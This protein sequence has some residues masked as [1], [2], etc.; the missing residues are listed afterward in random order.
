VT[1]KAGKGRKGS[2][3]AIIK[4]TDAKTVMEVLL[5]IDFKKLLAVRTVTLDMSNSMDWIVRQCF[6]NCT[7]IIDRFH[8][9]RLIS[10]AVQSLRV[11]YRWKVLEEENELAQIARKERVS[12]QS[13][14]YENGDSKKQLLA[15]SRYILFKT[16]NTWTESQKQRATILF[17]EYP[18]LKR[19]YELA[20]KFKYIYQTSKTKEK[21]QIR[22]QQWDRQVK[23]SNINYLITASDTVKSHEG[24]ILNYFPDRLTNA[25]AESFNAKLKGFRAL[26]RGILDISFFLFRVSKIYA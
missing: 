16:E 11:E 15:R 19:A 18:E 17:R 6:L 8:V 7:K 3:V 24:T 1:N 13:H 14:R 2:I 26:Q 23:E 10:E 5:K 9:E 4:G 12:Y 22:L 20:M 21:A 25:G